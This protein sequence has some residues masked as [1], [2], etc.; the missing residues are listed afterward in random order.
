[1]PKYR[2]QDQRGNELS[3]SPPGHEWWWLGY[4]AEVCKNNGSGTLYLR[5]I[6]CI[7]SAINDLLLSQ[8]EEHGRTDFGCYNSGSYDETKE[9]IKMASASAA[10]P[11][12][13]TVVGSSVTGSKS[14]NNRKGHNVRF[15][16]TLNSFNGLQAQHKT[17]ASLGVPVSSELAFAKKFEAWELTPITANPVLSDEMARTDLREANEELGLPVDS[18]EYGIGAQILRD[19]DVQSMKLMTNNPSKYIGLKV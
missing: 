4:D 19:L 9:I 15:I 3:P 1:M 13:I 8:V 5:I 10:S 14:R 11:S 12:T 17:V 18:R 7:G 16:T 6:V 2:T